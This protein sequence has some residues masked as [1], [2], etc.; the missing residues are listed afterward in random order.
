MLQ[1]FNNN[2]DLMDCNLT[3]MI[4]SKPL[5]ASKLS[6]SSTA[7]TLCLHDVERYLLSTVASIAGSLQGRS[8]SVG[9]AS[10]RASIADAV[11]LMFLDYRGQLCLQQSEMRHPVWRVE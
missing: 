3:L 8:P 7:K 11:N 10:R 6:A 5:I 1:C 2:H 4:S 9:S